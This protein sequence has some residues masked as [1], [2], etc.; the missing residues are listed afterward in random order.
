MAQRPTV[1]D[2]LVERLEGVAASRALQPQAPGPKAHEAGP[3]AQE[4]AEV[5]ARTP[6]RVPSSAQAWPHPQA[7]WPC[8]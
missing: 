7:Y 5:Q 4:E 1:A 3:Q 6:Q 8:E 2:M